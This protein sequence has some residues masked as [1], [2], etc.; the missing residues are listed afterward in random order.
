MQNRSLHSLFRIT[1]RG[2][3]CS[4]SLLV[5]IS[6][7]N[8]YGKHRT[9]LFNTRKKEDKPKSFEVNFSGFYFGDLEKRLGTYEL[10]GELSEWWSKICHENGVD[11]NDKRFKNVEYKYSELESGIREEGVNSSSQQQ[12]GFKVE[13]VVSGQTKVGRND[14][15]PCGSGKKFK[16]C[17]G[18]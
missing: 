2:S 18:K 12:G 9:F 5:K 17:H 8:F 13:K 3:R 11:P 10:V 7:K 6:F 4:A 16:N 1:A 14:P 15:C